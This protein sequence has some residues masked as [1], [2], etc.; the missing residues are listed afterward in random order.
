M[1]L[2]G[3]DN[4]DFT[5]DKAA[6]P[7][8][9]FCMQGDSCVWRH[10]QPCSPALHLGECMTWLSGRQVPARPE[11]G[12]AAAVQL[13]RPPPPEGDQR[14]GATPLPQESVQLP[15]ALFSRNTGQCTELIVLAP[16]RNQLLGS[17]VQVC[18]GIVACTQG[19]AH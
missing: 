14:P 13:P 12:A 18:V 17:P 8:V 4:P 7:P 15:G 9:Q 6:L 1:R 10:W 2:Q 19:G 16:C 3:A 5:I 11:V